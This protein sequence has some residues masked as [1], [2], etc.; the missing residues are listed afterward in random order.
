MW[1]KLLSLI[2]FKELFKRQLK[3]L[4]FFM[5]FPRKVLFIMVL[6]RKTQRLREGTQ[7]DFEYLLYLSILALYELLWEISSPRL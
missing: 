2:P 5:A 7:R 1:R 6:P 3:K 4:S